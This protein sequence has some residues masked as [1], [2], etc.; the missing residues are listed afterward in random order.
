MTAPSS[1]SAVS[2]AQPG[3]GH[4]T[5]TILELWK[6]STDLECSHSFTGFAVVVVVAGAWG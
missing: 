6:S 3:N 2:Y 5:L 4:L 1:V